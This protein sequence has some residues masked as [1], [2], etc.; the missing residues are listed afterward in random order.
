MGTDVLGI[1]YTNPSGLLV[2]TLLV[3]TVWRS[4]AFEIHTVKVLEKMIASTVV[5]GETTSNRRSDVKSRL[6][7]EPEDRQNVSMLLQTR[8]SS[9]KMMVG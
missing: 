5:F 2:E 7:I 3:Y 4:R 1:T 6:P 9:T 8:R